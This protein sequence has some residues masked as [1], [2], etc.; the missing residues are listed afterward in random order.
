MFDYPFFGAKVFIPL[1][2]AAILAGIT[3]GVLRLA[4]PFLIPICL[5]YIYIVFKIVEWRDSRK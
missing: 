1:A 3:G 5:L 4:W 2:I